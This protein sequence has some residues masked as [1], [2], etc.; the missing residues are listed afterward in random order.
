MQHIAIYYF[1]G[2]GKV[3]RFEGRLAILLDRSTGEC[4]ENNWVQVAPHAFSFSLTG[5][6][7]LRYPYYKEVRKCL[8]KRLLKIR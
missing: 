4:A 8:Q 1:M 3:E 5:L 2:N 7:Y 6:L